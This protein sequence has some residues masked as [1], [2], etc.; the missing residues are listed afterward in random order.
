VADQWTYAI[1]LKDLFDACGFALFSDEQGVVY[2]AVR[3]PIQ[4]VAPRP[5]GN[6]PDAGTVSGTLVPSTGT[7]D[8][9]TG[10][11]RWVS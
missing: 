3:R 10:A 6:A 4:A 7:V 11:P 2:E 8:P 1:A 9:F 5:P